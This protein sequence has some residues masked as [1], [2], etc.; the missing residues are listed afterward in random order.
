MPLEAALEL[1]FEPFQEEQFAAEECIRDLRPTFG[2][3]RY[4]ILVSF[5]GS[6][7]FAFLS[8]QLRRFSDGLSTTVKRGTIE[9]AG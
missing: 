6:V 1:L 2:K 8:R 4:Y 7:L 5:G 3:D 9:G